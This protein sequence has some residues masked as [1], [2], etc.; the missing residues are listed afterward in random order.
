[1]QRELAKV[2]YIDGEYVF[3]KT[4]NMSACGECSSKTSCG[5]VKL[6]SPVVDSEDIKIK[7]TLDLKAGDSVVLELAPS[8]LL[9]GTFLVYLFPLIL[10]MIFAVLGKMIGGEGVSII[11]GLV[12]LVISL[13]LVNKY[14]A[15][16]TVSQQFTP[17]IT[18]IM[19]EKG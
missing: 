2:S 6:F 18:P 8:K 11:A 16:K 5:S 4:S 19:L 17:S 1:M 7:N 12:G 14:L 9:Q 13:F 10:M 15:K 3:L